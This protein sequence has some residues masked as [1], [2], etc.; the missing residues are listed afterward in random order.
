MLAIVLLGADR[1]IDA[2]RQLAEAGTGAAIVLASGFGEAGDEGQRRQRELKEAA[3]S[4]RS[5]ARTPSAS[6]T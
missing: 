5:S 6:S 4:M 3:G 2:V 1:V